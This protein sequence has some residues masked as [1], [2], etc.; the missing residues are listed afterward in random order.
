M[1]DLEKRV[2]YSLHELADTV[3][4]SADPRGELDRRLTGRRHR[5]FRGP[6][7]AVAAAAAA[8][9]AVVGVTVPLATRHDADPTATERTKDGLVWSSDYEWLVAD[10]GPFVLGGFTRN[11][12]KIDAVAWVRGGAL[13]VG[14]GHHVGVGTH[15]PK[16]TPGHLIGVTC[17]AVPTWPAGPDAHVET[18]AVLSA[19]T[20]DSGPLPELMLFL[21]APDVDTL[22]VDG[23]DGT[24]VRLRGLATIDGLR[25]FLAD[26]DGSTQ[27]F[28]Y[29]TW[30]AAGN[31]LESA[32]T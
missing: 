17:D 19:G 14:E 32:I 23:G 28:G 15:G 9:V 11:G 5:S 20:P 7:L 13:C 12:E 8:V 31:V 10:A 30:D 2:R 26:F 1:T 22:V 3:P 4:A 16:K 25:L 18:R 24:P 6:A 21:T 27:G 29:T